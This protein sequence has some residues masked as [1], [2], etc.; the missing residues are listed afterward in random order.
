MGLGL[1]MGTSAEV[2]AQFTTNGNAA[3]VAGSPGCWNLTGDYASQSGQIWSTTNVD[4]SQHFDMIADVRLSNGNNDGG[5]DGL[6]FVLRPPTA[7]ATGIGGGSM[8]FGG[9]TP[10][11]VVD[12]DTYANSGTP[13]FDPNNDHIG[14]QRNGSNLHAG[15]NML[16]A[17][18]S[19]L[20]PAG[21]IETGNFYTLRVTYNPDTDVFKV[22]FN[23]VERISTTVDLAAILGTNLVRWGFT[24]GTGGL[25]NQHRVCN[26]VWVAGMGNF[27]PASV[28]AC[29]GAPTVLAI[30]PG[31]TGVSWSP[32]TA[33]SA[34]TGNTVTASPTVSTTYTVTYNNLC[35]VAT[36]EQITVQVAT[37]PTSTA[38]VAA[39]SCNGAPIELPNGP[40]PPGVTG[41]WAGGSTAPVLA[42]TESG[43]YTLTV[44]DAST[45]CSATYFT[46]VSAIALAPVDLGPDQTVCP[47]S[48]V[49]LD[50]SGGNTGVT[51]TWN[52]TVGPPVYTLPGPGTYIAVASQGTCSVRDTVSLA[53]HP[54]YPLNL[55]AGPL[56]L[57]QGGTL[58]LTAGNAAWTGPPVG[59]VWTT[60]AIG[61]VLNVDAP[62]FYG[63]E[64]TTDVCTFSGGIEVVDSPNQG[65]DLGEDLVLCDAA[66]AVLSSGYPAANTSW[67]AVASGGSGGG[68]AVVA[69]TYPV[70]GA[71]ATIAVEVTF[72]ACV[73]RDTVQVNH[74]PLFDPGLPTT[75][76][77]CLNDSVLL[78]ALPGADSYAWNDGITG[79]IRW[80]TAP[81]LYTVSAPLTGC[82]HADAVQVVPSA[83]TGVNLGEDIVLCDG[84]T[85]T[86]TSGYGAS[87][88]TWYLNGAW[89]GNAA[90]WTV[91]GED[92]VVVAEI[93]VGA[94][95]AYDTLQ[96]DHVPYFDA[97]LPDNASVCAGDSLF[98]SATPGAPAYSWNTGAQGPGIWVSEAG[99][100][101]VSTP[102]QG[103]PHTDAT[104][105]T[106]VP[107]PDFDLGPDVAFCEGEWA[108]L[109]TGLFASDQTT[110][111]TGATGPVLQVSEP[112]SVGV[113]VTIDGCTA[114]DAV[115][116]TVHPLPS[117]ELGPDRTLCPGE[118]TLLAAGLLP[119]GTD[120]TWSTGETTP[121]IEA[122]TTAVYSATA[123]LLGCTWTD[124]ITVVIA[125]P[126]SASV[127]LDLR[128]CGGD[129]L[130]INL[131]NPPNAFPTQYLWSTGATTPAIYIDRPGRFDATV[132]NLCETIS[133]PF[134]VR[135]EP[136]DCSAWVPSAFTPDN[137]GVNDAFQPVLSCTPE[138]YNLRIFNAWGQLIFATDDPSVAWMGQTEPNP[139]TS[140]HAGYFGPNAIYH[141]TLELAFPET[142]TTL[143]RLQASR[144]TVVVV[145]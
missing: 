54:S 106:V 2:Q 141:W 75:V 105:L 122:S 21:N 82:P 89:A 135:L 128:L 16:A 137:D 90:Q 130:F 124:Q 131:E 88:T 61:P 64:V 17:P 109:S 83:N 136:C 132:S 101:T 86:A 37:L 97:G 50:G 107:L 116:V 138:R 3:A 113:A 45:G 13:I 49:A 29:A 121:W 73:T 41:A 96:V 139:A 1:V 7:T 111:T 19:A 110:W 117:F 30:P 78:A 143:P 26:P 119:P 46:N 10:S 127:P 102:I 32:A 60:G 79:P 9:I 43:T 100:Y 104:L 120:L 71:D 85:Y 74:V 112:G 27:L 39:V 123:D 92:V 145:R 35:N 12:L 134:E 103:C 4:V 66:T 118:T 125:A 15:A 94:C 93:V 18:V 76:D 140:D 65:V 23:C 5:A 8:G 25:S 91:A 28:T 67:T 144:G 72:G 114:S 69:A 33:L 47:G 70:G 59:F 53:W 31:I 133:T 48:V 14:V 129:S 80:V 58:D 62:G 95:L 51:V 98:L 77:I 87:A 126:L 52:G 68:P 81:G 6:A 142:E 44:T 38:P 22:F 57:C 55:G 108:L 56:E 42:V 99:I 34:T 36:T 20:N 115:Q 24:A 63:V 40:W 11:L 84:N